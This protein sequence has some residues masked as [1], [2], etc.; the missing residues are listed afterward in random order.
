MF[1]RIYEEQWGRLA[2]LYQDHSWREKN[3]YFVL[4]R[5]IHIDIEEKSAGASLLSILSNMVEELCVK[6]V[7][8]QRLNVQFLL[9]AMESQIKRL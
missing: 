1:A 2:C 6:V 3:K 8:A 9:P 5:V 4:L 7:L